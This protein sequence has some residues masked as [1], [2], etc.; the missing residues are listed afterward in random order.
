MKSLRTNSLL[1]SFGPVS[2]PNPIPKLMNKLKSGKRIAIALLVGASAVMTDS[3]TNAQTTPAAQPGICVRA[4]WGARAPACQPGN[5]AALTRAIVHHTA[6]TGD[7]TTDY[8]G[9]KS[10][11]R[12][13]QNYHIDSAGFCDISYHFLVNAGGHI[14]EG[15]QGAMTGL[16][17]S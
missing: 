3:Q 6:G 8:E 16:P 5:I 2:S 14:Y 11:V 7:W 13:I 4:C 15:R 10:R 12:G 9:G 1:F 17:R